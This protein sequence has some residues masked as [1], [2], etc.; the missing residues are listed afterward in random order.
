MGNQRIQSFVTLS[1]ASP[2]ILQSISRDDRARLE[3]PVISWK[4]ALDRGKRAAPVRK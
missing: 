3:Y 2:E 4:V 1:E